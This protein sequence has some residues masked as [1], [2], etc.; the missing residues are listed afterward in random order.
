[1]NT[2]TENLARRF[3]EAVAE[4]AGNWDARL[5]APNCTDADRANFTQWV[6]EDPVHRAAF[7]ELQAA[8]ATLRD[9]VS[10]ADVRALR[11]AALAMAHRLRRRKYAVAASVCLF[12]MTA[13]LISVS[14]ELWAGSNYSTGIGQQSTVTL[15]D[16]SSVLL[17][18]SS[19]IKV[20]F[21]DE[22]RYIKLVKGQ[23]LFRVAKNPRRPFIVRA[24]DRE[25]VAL[26]TSFDV[27]LEQHSVRVTLIEGKV[28][29]ERASGR[30][31]SVEV[32]QAPVRTAA[33][34]KSMPRTVSP[35]EEVLL[36]PGQQFVAALTPGSG[37]SSGV[38]EQSTSLV[39][40]ID[41][42]KVTGWRNGRVFLEDMS[43]TEAVE[44]MNR[45]SQIKV[46]IDDPELRQVRVNGMFRAGEQDAFVAALEEYFPIGSSRR[47]GEIVLTARN[48]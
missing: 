1:M 4:Q 38:I 6:N 48:R 10:R 25:V 8:V 19:K 29:V 47:E 41:V 30:S 11:D 17:N 12:F 2:G 23:A 13:G 36:T 37:T 31:D 3:P 35:S 24:G 40:A 42:D 5:R 46:V 22:R 7:E 45:H 33:V 15:P 28:S 43:L 32:K 34:R 39:R 14:G 9:E 20:L 16:G 21:S 18:A 27:R 44:E 26:G